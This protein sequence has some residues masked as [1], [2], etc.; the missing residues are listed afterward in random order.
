VRGRYECFEAVV[1]F[2]E[3]FNSV[4]KEERE[5]PSER[6]EV[7][8]DAYYANPADRQGKNPLENITFSKNKS[9]IPA[10]YGNSSRVPFIPIEEE[11]ERRLPQP[12]PQLEREK[13]AIKNSIMSMNLSGNYSQMKA[14]SNVGGA[15]GNLSKLNEEP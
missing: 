2:L 10:T 7:I 15:Q 6:L 4:L 11:T 13:E 9:S 1:P 12:V 14:K 8:I 5:V 3:M